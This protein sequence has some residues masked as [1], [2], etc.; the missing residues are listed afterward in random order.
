MAFARRHLQNRDTWGILQKKSGAKFQ[1]RGIRSLLMVI[2]SNWFQLW[3]PK[4]V[5]P[6]I[7]LRV[8]M[9]DNFVWHICWVLCK[10]SIGFFLL[11]FF[12]FFQY[13]KEINVYPK[14]IYNCNNSC[15]KWCI[16]WKNSRGA[17]AFIH[18]CKQLVRRNNKPPVVIEAFN[19]H[20]PLKL[21]CL[22]MSNTN[23]WFVTENLIDFIIFVTPIWS[24]SPE[25]CT[26][27]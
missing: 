11:L 13:T 27:N 24:C 15:E 9:H 16:L 18:D 26:K 8:P 20:N 10:M 17:N 2:G 6:D 21:I 3:F 14:K 25:I 19:E 12:A 1:L 5:Q 22:L 4:G 7:K 23:D